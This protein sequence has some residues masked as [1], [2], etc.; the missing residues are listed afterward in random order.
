[1]SADQQRTEKAL[2]LLDFQEAKERLAVLRHKADEI[3]GELEAAAKLL[4]E[5]PETVEFHG[6]RLVLKGYMNFGKLVEDIKKTIADLQ[7]LES[8][9][10]QGGIPHTL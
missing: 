1:M 4:K 7:R 9:L 8:R 6:D 2:L 10:T 5:C 3:A